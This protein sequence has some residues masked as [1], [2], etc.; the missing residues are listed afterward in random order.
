MVK[1]WRTVIHCNVKEMWI[2]DSRR[3]S[4]E[5]FLSIESFYSSMKLLWDSRTTDTY[6]RVHVGVGIRVSTVFNQ[7]R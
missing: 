1:D 5:E 6:F 2:W 3:D 7:L 4:V